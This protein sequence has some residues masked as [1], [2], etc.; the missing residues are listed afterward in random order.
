MIL[1][2]FKNIFIQLNFLF[3]FLAC[4]LKSPYLCALS[5]QIS[6]FFLNLRN[7]SKYKKKILVLFKSFGAEDIETLKK[8]KNNDYK[9]LYMQ[10]RNVKIIFDYFFSKINHDL[11]DD[12]YF[13]DDRLVQI[14][15]VEYRNFLKN[16]LQIFN[17]KSNFLAIVSFN[18]RYRA[19]K[20][21]HYICKPLNIKFIVCHKESLDLN[22]DHPKTDLYIDMN[23]KNGKYNGDY[24]TVYTENF[25]NLL[26]KTS[27][28]EADKIYVI[29]MPRADYYY[30]RSD[31]SK[32]HILYLLPS[33]IAPKFLD[34]EF[35]IKDYSN[36]VTKLILE[37]AIKNPNEKIIIKTKVFKKEQDFLNEAIMK[38][39]LNNVILQKG[40]NS[41]NLI[42][43]AK[44]VI[45]FQTTALIE[46]LILRKTIIVPYFN[47]NNSDKLKR[48]T[49]K[50]E[51]LTYYA[52]DELSMMNYLNKFLLSNLDPLNVKN[53]EIDD[54]IDHYLGN[55]DGKSS[56]RLLNFFNKV[57]N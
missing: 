5:W 15:K 28:I 35:N 21:L 10:R 6:I 2:N 48:F 53:E 32:K 17:K 49:L 39:K 56:E 55:T 19:E 25:K 37:F 57:L 9:F 20:E 24:M 34:K 22:D 7:R 45:G 54:I 31:V 4:R 40:G 11:T 44:L 26:V 16:T 13:S 51:N 12:K 36:A 42:K 47:I 30:N 27:I 23:S 3:L 29:G 18:Y 1:K 38:N 46:A 41:A 8:N 14:T 33:W 43:D 50:L 52:Y